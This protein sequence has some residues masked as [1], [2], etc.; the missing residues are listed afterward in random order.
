MEI[1]HILVD[2]QGNVYVNYENIMNESDE[3][4]DFV[5]NINLVVM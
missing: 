2:F 4:L 3:L 1:M 5:Q